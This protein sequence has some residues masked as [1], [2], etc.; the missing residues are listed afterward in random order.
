M[1][2][3]D[4]SLCAEIIYGNHFSPE[5]G[6]SGYQVTLKRVKRSFWWPGMRT[7]IELVIRNFD[8]CQRNKIENVASPGYLQPLPVPEKVWEDIVMDFIK[9]LPSSQGLSFIWVIV[10][11]FSKFESFIPLKASLHC[12]SIGSDLPQRNC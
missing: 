2:D 5:R 6:H 11:R 3:P 4:D 9:G 8:I 10:D 7:D 12:T 1:I